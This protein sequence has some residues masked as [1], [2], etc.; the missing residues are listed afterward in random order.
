LTQKQPPLDPSELERRILQ[1]LSCEWEKALWVLPRPEREKMIRPLF[2]LRDFQDRW[3]SWHREKREIALSRKL[4]WNHS[5][6]AVREVL[7]H[8]TAHQ[9]ADEVLGASLETPHGPQFQK[10]CHLLRANPRASG[11]YPPLD[12]R[13]RAG[14]D[15]PADKNLLRIRKLMALAASPNRH[16][17][18]AA[19]AKAH[20]LMRKYNLGTPAEKE[21]FFET[22]SLSRPALRHPAEEYA[23]ANLLQEF[24]FVQGIWVPAFVLERNRMGRVL[25]ISGT[26][27]NLQAAGYV[28]DFVSRFIRA[29]WRA[30]NAGKNLGRRRRTDFALGVIEGFRSK[31]KSGNGANPMPAALL[32]L[33]NPR[34]ESYMAYRYPRTVRI[35]GGRVR[36]DRQVIEDGKRAGRKL[37]IAKGVESAAKSR[38]LRLAAG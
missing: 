14:E 23:L 13:F 30:Y 16:E 31:L 18:E 26:F 10:A 8:E 4:V 34:L 37:V 33:E 17:A 5:W 12:E 35:S 21:I 1:G 7:L 20:E 11:T 38:S 28:Y 22:L 3:G 19:M 24:Y 2:Q 9:L 15:L 36:R 6:D 25:E 32:R 29:E 27:S